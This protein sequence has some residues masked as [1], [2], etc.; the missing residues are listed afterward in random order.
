MAKRPVT[1]AELRDLADHMRQGRAYHRRSGLL[2]SKHAK[3]CG[4]DGLSARD[5]EMMA[6]SMETRAIEAVTLAPVPE[7]TKFIEPPKAVPKVQ[8]ST[9]AQ[10]ELTAYLLDQRDYFGFKRTGSNFQNR[11]VTLLERIPEVPRG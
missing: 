5:I 3:R 11:K 2:L 9:S 8:P 6:L 10:Q 1:V 4:V 7:P